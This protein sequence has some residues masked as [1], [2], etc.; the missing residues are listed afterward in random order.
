MELTEPFEAAVVAAAH[1]TELAIPNRVSL[2]SMFPPAWSP[3]ECLINL[4]RREGGISTLFGPQPQGNERD[5]QNR[6]RR[7]KRP[8]LARVS[9]H[10][11]KRV[12]ERGRN[13]EDGQELKKI[14]EW[15]RILKR[16][17]GIHIEEAA[18][19]GAEL[20]DRDLGSRRSDRKDLFRRRCGFSFWLSLFIQ[21]RLSVR[22]HDWFVVR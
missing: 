16:M 6:H 7:K 1:R 9:N 12:A 18:T 5:Q 15:R 11:S 20:L 2:P 17:R 4:H 10:H 14:G 3:R 19:I 22:I 13:Q 8:T 21:Y